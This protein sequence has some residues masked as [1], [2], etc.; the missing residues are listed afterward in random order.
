MRSL[1][2]LPVAF[3]L[4]V[5]VMI[6][7]LV[8][9]AHAADPGKVD[10]FLKVT[11]FDVALESIRLS[12]DSAPLMLGIDA[13]MFGS[14]WSRLVREIF[15]TDVMLTMGSDILTETLDDDVLE[16]ASAFYASDLGQRLVAAENASHMKKDDAAKSEGGKAIIAG[17]KRIGSPRL[18]LLERLNAASNVEDSS[19]RAMQE[20]QIRFLMAAANAGVIKL[21]MEEPDLRAA[22]RAQEQD[23]RA[24][25]KAN[26]LANAA[27]TYQAFS[28]AE[29]AAY[30][31]A[32]EH[33][34]MQ[35][36]YALMNAVQFEIMANRYE[37]VAQRLSTMQP[38]QDL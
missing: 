1:A 24:S 21:Q 4:S 37:A 27:Y 20:V 10:A 34:K 8:P 11:G 19:I 33:P 2:R 38:S 7:C 31:S 5:A 12:A 6:S 14:E 13:S 18:A 30:A 22:I 29:I 26:A 32:L 23:M 9:P 16:H 17:L 36:V 28:D 25:V 3:A 15:D 35:E